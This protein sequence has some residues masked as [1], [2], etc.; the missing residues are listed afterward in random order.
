[1][2]AELSASLIDSQ[3]SENHQ[4]A[5][6]CPCE[7]G[8]LAS[9]DG[10]KRMLGMSERFVMDLFGEPLA[11]YDYRSVKVAMFACHHTPITVMFSKGVVVQ[12]EQCSEQRRHP[13]VRPEIPVGVHI[14]FGDDGDTLN[15]ELLDISVASLAMECFSLDYP[16]EGSVVDIWI[17]GIGN[18]QGY[19]YRVDVHSGRVVVMIRDGSVD[20]PAVRNYVARRLVES[21]PGK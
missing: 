8:L 21:F 13:R 2:Y 14:T 12:I 4:H 10:A 17:D 5:I 18:L 7:K 1:M 11:L 19:I 6:N 3:L 20:M 16:G 9:L 15:G